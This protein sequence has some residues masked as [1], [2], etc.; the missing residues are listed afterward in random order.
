MTRVFTGGG[1]AGGEEEARAHA[2][3]RTSVAKRRGCGGARHAYEEAMNFTSV[4]A[5]TSDDDDNEDDAA[6]TCV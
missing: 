1:R 4:R 6:F 2:R 3:A 5:T